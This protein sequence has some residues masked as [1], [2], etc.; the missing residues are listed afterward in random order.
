MSN[1]ELQV[2]V[3]QHVGAGIEPGL[4]LGKLFLEIQAG[5]GSSSSEVD[6]S[7]FLAVALEQ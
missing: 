7:S 1:L 3:D 5:H 6:F 4:F 2:I